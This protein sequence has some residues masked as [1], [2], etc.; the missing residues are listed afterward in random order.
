MAPPGATTTELVLE[1]STDGTLWVPLANLRGSESIVHP[2]YEATLSHST[3]LSQVRLRA[4]GT[5]FSA[6]RPF[7]IERLSELSFFE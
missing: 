1:G 3:A 7:Y 4:A 6:D 5:G 2:F